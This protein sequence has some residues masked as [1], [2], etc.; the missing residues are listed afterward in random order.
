MKH[1]PIGLSNILRATVFLA[2]IFTTQN[3]Y[4]NMLALSCDILNEGGFAQ[5]SFFPND[6][7]LFR[8]HA[9]APKN[10]KLFNPNAEYRIDFN[11]KAVAIVKGFSIPYNLNESFS[12]PVRKVDDSFSA[13]KEKSVKL[14]EIHGKLKLIVNANIAYSKDTT[15]TAV[16]CEKILTIN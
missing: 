5:T 10:G 16:T 3:T 7:A 11:V 14:P 6:I 13:T 4:A 12:I 8:V 2:F 9:I 15:S 1:Q